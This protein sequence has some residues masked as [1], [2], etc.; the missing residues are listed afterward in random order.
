MRYPIIEGGKQEHHIGRMFLCFKFGK[1]IKNARDL[2]FVQRMRPAP[3]GSARNHC[4]PA[5][6]VEKRSDRGRDPLGTSEKLA[7]LHTWA[8]QKKRRR[9]Q[10]I[11]VPV[12]DVL[13]AENVDMTAAMTPNGETGGF[14]GA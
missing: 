3:R 9:A 13:A 4:R 2:V 7:T 10:G 6:D 14:C 12:Y 1:N 8:I 5:H 11:E